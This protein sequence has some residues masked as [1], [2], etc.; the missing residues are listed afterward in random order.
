V[1]STSGQQYP[2]ARETG[3]KAMSPYVLDALLWIFQ[4]R[5]HIPHHDDFGASHSGSP[6]ATRGNRLTLVLAVFVLTVA[7]LSVALWAA[8][9]LAIEL[10]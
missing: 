1:P 4:I 3:A 8:V 2:A 7:L 6:L 5:G 9:W 10:L